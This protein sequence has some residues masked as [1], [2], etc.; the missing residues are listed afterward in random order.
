VSAVAVRRKRR[1][2]P[3]FH[4]GWVLGSL[5]AAENVLVRLLG[6]RSRP[7]HHHISAA[8]REVR[9]AITIVQ[10]RTEAKT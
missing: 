6:N 2:Q 7:E 1:D 8:F 4:D 10:K 9:A 5:W 3:A